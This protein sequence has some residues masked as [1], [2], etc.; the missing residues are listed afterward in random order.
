LAQLP[1]TVSVLTIVK[2]RPGHLAQLVEGLRRST[3]PPDELII[4]DMGSLVPVSV[5]DVPFPVRLSR[6]ECTGLPLAAARNEAARMATGDTLLFL[7]VDCIPM[8]DLV[9]AITGLVE[10]QNALVCA[11]IW[12]LGPDDA[13]TDWTESDL[14][15]GAVGHPVREFPARGFREEHNA[16]L[17]WSLAFGIRRA[18]FFDLRGFD[19]TFTGYGAEDT[20]FGFRAKA[21]A[22]PLYFLGGVGAFHQYHAVF[23]PPLQHM[24]DIV[25]NAR[26]FHERWGAWPMEGWLAQFEKAGFICRNDDKLHILRIP[27]V[28]DMERVRSPLPG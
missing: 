23:D 25:R 8:R 21:A 28:H 16:G 10:S 19:E 3:V 2:D 24:E 14:L 6:L 13:R 15:I 20:D 7:D 5:G 4:V 22:L 12:Y 9:G 18:Q 17:F 11:E 26:L 27:G 1:V